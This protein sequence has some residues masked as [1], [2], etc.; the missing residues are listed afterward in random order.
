MAALINGHIS[1][2]EKSIVQQVSRCSWR[3]QTALCVATMANL[4]EQRSLTSN[5]CRHLANW[6]KHTR[7]LWFY[8]FAPLCENVTPATK[9]GVHN[10]LH[11]YQR[12]DWA[13]AIYNMHRQEAQLPQRDHKTCYVS[14]F[15]LCFTSYGKVPSSQWPSRSFK[16]NGNWIGYIR[17]PISLPLQGLYLAPFPRYYHLFPKI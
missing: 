13:A 9:P 7:H 4:P 12:K 10:T 3:Q 15:M 2:T 17:F 14:K 11:C 6:T 5:W 1:L 8:P 16:G